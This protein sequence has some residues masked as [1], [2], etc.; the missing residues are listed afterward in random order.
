[1]PRYARGFDVGLAHDHLSRRDRKLAVWMRRLGPIEAD[2][3]W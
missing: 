2:A 3:R 1:M